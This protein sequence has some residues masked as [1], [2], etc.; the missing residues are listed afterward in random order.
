MENLMNETNIDSETDSAKST[1][2]ALYRAIQCI[3]ALHHPVG[4]YCSECNIMYP[5]HTYIDAQHA[6]AI[7]TSLARVMFDLVLPDNSA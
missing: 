7:T 1:L 6:Q 4:E 3:I 5:C 2:T